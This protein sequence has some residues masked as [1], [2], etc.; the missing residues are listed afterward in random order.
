[1]YFTLNHFYHYF[2]VV[3]VGVSNIGHVHVP[4][5]IAG[6]GDVWELETWRPSEAIQPT[7]LVAIEKRTCFLP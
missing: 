6:Q 5:L 2:H 3:S 7:A 4:M 1:M